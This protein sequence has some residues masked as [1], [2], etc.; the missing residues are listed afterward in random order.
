[1]ELLI[2]IVMK[3]TQR[4]GEMIIYIFVLFSMFVNNTVH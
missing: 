4:N 1:M 3:V 2:G